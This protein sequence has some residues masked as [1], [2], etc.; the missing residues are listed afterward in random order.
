MK[1]LLAGLFV[2]AAVALAK[3]SWA[4]P[5]V[6]A[7]DTTSYPIAGNAVIAVDDPSGD[8]RITGWSENRVEVVTTRTSWSSDDLKRMSTTVDAR[9]DRLALGV[10]IPHGCLNC[11]ISFSIRAPKG[12]HVAIETASGDIK[13]TAIDG[14]V[15]ADSSSGGVEIRDAHGEVHVHASSGDI[16]L[17]HISSIVDAVTSSGDIKATGLASDTDLRAASGSLTADFSSFGD[18]HHVWLESS[19]G[20]ITFVVPRGTGFRLD[21]DT[22]SGSID[23]NLA[24]PIRERDSGASVGAQVGKGSTTVQ[25]R[26]TSGD[27]SVKMR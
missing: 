16:T 8:V 9:H 17:D 10:Q 26:A 19:S 24:L 3:P 2:V 22:T 15:H 11:D 14:P 5:D 4:W 6:H 25:L 20:D 7:T 13:V 27:I 21:A 1:M 12:V 18:V 23:S